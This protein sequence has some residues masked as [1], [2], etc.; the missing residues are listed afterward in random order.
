MDLLEQHLTKDILSR[1]DCTTT[2]TNLRTKF[3]NAFNSEFEERM[4]KYTRYN[5]QSFND[6]MICTMDSIR[7]YMLEIILHQQQTLHL[8]KQKTL[9]QTQE[10]HSHQTQAVNTDSLKVDLVVKQN[11]CSEKE[12]NN[13]ETASSKSPKECIHLNSETQYSSFVKETQK[14][15]V[16]NMDQNRKSCLF[17]G[18]DVMSTFHKNNAP[19][20]RANYKINLTKMNFK[21][22]GSSQPSVNRGSTLQRYT[23]PTP[24]MLKSPFLKNTSSKIS[25]KRGVNKDRFADA[26][27]SGN[28]T[29]ADDADIRPIYAEEPMAEEI[30][31]LEI[32]NIELEHSG[33]KLR[34]E[35]ETLK[36]HYKDFSDSGKVFAIVALKNDLRKLKGNSVDTKFDK[37]SVLGKPVLPSLRNQLVVRLPNAFKSKRTQMLKQRF[38]SQVDVNK[39]L[40]K[41]VTQHYLPKKTESAF[42]KP[43]HMIASS[44]SRNSSKN[45][46]RM[47]WIPTRKLFDSCTSKVD[48]EP[49]HGLNIDILNIHECKQPLDL[50]ST[51]Y[52]NGEKSS[53]LKS[54]AVTTTDASNKRQQQ[55]DSTSSTSTLATTV[56]A[57]GNFDL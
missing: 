19:Q 45:M 43:D 14:A 11:S 50:R 44:S 33:A 1:T 54:F 22:S 17:F 6:A 53:C 30:D 32:M 36:Q 37:T 39:N 3:E 56:T 38:A 24:G 13:S 5:A 12:D 55:P 49:P 57:D 52:F 51:R 40:S 7:K 2:L 10:D 28:D 27:K 20:R 34:K 47:R 23:T 41:L 29:D 25:M 15:L 16:S 9:M 4:R 42:A 21:K 46:P 18:Q 48:S 26:R 31:V 35:N 8:L